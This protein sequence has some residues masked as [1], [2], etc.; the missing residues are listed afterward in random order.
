MYDGQLSEQERIVLRA[1]EDGLA[2]ED[3]AFVVRF[4]LDAV[5]L[6]AAPKLRRRSVPR[7]L[8]GDGA[9]EAQ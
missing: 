6:S 4:R 3:P 8:R 2:D 5:A 7:W 9:D 1:V